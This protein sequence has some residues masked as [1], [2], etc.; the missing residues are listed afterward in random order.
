M[1]FLI[2]IIIIIAA[3]SFPNFRDAFFSAKGWKRLWILIS[4]IYLL[5]VIFVA[6]SMF[7]SQD[8]IIYV[9]EAFLWWIIP[10]ATVYGLG[11]AIGWVLKGFKN[12]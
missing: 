10:V 9:S 7:H 8:L 4:G 1:W 11:Y 12:L 6:I 5:L 2:V 3:V